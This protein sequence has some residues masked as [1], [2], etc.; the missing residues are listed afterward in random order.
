M[1]AK[2]WCVPSG[3]YIVYLF[4]YKNIYHVV[5]WLCHKSIHSLIDVNL[6]RYMSH[7]FFSLG[8]FWEVVVENVLTVVFHQVSLKQ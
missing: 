6:T 5:L 2:I 7:K 4:V 1:S 8:P 3:V